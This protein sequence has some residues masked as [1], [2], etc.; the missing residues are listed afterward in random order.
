MKTLKRLSKP[1]RVLIAACLV[2]TAIAFFTSWQASAARAGGA[3]NVQTP[4]KTTR[5]KVYSKDQATR[6][7]AVYSAHCDKCH[8]PAK[9]PEGKKPPPPIVGAKFKETWQDKTL[10]ELYTLVLTTMPSD[11]S[12]VLTPDETLD[13][14]AHLL[15]L[16]E[17][18]DGTAPL[19]NDD[20]MKGIVIVKVPGP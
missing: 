12:A 11:G 14:L 16:N 9:L 10:G 8:D 6:G 3:V 15:K 13:V 2:F 7:A 4:A 20:A 17:Y 18:P 5:D 19:K 1:A